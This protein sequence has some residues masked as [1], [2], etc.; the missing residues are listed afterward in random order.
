MAMHITAFAS[1]NGIRHI[2]WE[3]DTVKERAV[4]M[5]FR[6][7]M[8]SLAVPVMPAVFIGIK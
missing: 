3:L 1:C 4:S 2:C 5:F 6:L 8:I 7:Q